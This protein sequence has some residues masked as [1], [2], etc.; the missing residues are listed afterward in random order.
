M[1][2]LVLA[3]FSGV[4]TTSA[5]SRRAAAESANTSIELTLEP[6]YVPVVQ[7]AGPRNEMW[8]A[9]QADSRVD[10]FD[11]ENWLLT[12]YDTVSGGQ[13]RRLTANGHINDFAF[14]DRDRVFVL[15]SNHALNTTVVMRVE[16]SGVQSFGE[17]E[18]PFFYGAQ[19]ELGRDGFIYIHGP[20]GTGSAL[21]QMDPDSLDVVN[22][23]T[24]VPHGQ[25]KAVEQGIVTHGV[26][27]ARLKPYGAS[28]PEQDLFYPPRSYG[29]ASVGD[30]GALHHLGVQLDPAGDSPCQLAQVSKVTLD[31]ELWVKELSE[32][33]S[34]ASDEVCIVR[35]I[36][37]LPDGGTVVT[38][39]R[40]RPEPAGN[41]GVVELYWLDRLG[42]FVDFR[43]PPV[44]ETDPLTPGF[45]FDGTGPLWL[46]NPAVTVDDV[47]NVA[48]A[49]A[50][51]DHICDPLMPLPVA[52]SNIYL[53]IYSPTLT[54]L[55]HGVVLPG[56]IPQEWALGGG[57]LTMVNGAIVVPF[58]RNHINEFCCATFHLALVRAND[59]SVG[60]SGPP[61]SEV[62]PAGSGAEGETKE[63]GDTNCDGFVRVAI[64]GDSYIS[65]EGA[66]DGITSTLEFN[67]EPK[68][69]EIGTDDRGVNQ[70]HRSQASWAWRVAADR[71]Q[72]DSIFFSACSGAVTHNVTFNGSPQWPV[73]ALL[74]GQPQSNSLNEYNQ[75][76]P[77]DLV[78]VSIG[79]ND[80]GFE[81]VIRDCLLFDCMRFP[82][83]SWRGDALREARTIGGRVRDTLLDIASSAPEAQVW[84]VGYPDPVAAR[85]CGATGPGIDFPALLTLLGFP[86]G[87][88]LGLLRIDR[89]EQAWI[90]ENFIGPLNQQVEAAAA[91]ANAQ[92][93]PFEN[94]FIGRDVCAGSDSAYTNGLK[95]GD[96]LPKPPGR[97]PLGAE[98]FHPNAMGHRHLSSVFWN[99]ATASGLL[100]SGAT[101]VAPSIQV[102][103]LPP[104]PSLTV[105][106]PPLNSSGLFVAAPG[107]PFALQGAGAPP[108]GSGVISFNS[109]P[110]IIG[111]FIADE[112]GAWTATVTIPASAAPGFHLLAAMTHDGVQLAS[113]L[114]PVNTSATCAPD[115]QSIDVD[116]DLLPN[117]CDPDQL[118]GPLA[119]FDEDTVA[120]DVDNCPALANTDQTDANDNG[121]GD[122][123]DPALGKPLTSG[124]RDLI[125]PTVVT[126][127][128]SLEGNVVGGFNG[129]IPP[130]LVSDPTDPVGVV[131]L[132]SDAPS[133]SPLGVSSVLWTAT[134]PSGNQAS[135]T[136]HVTVIDSV[137]P[138][139]TC[140][141]DVEATAG[142]SVVLGVATAIDIVDAAP[143]IASDAPLVFPNGLTS[144]VWT[145]RDGSGNTATCG[146]TV[147][148]TPAPNQAPTTGPDVYATPRNQGLTVKAPGVLGND[149]DPDPGDT[150]QA[151]LVAGASHGVVTLGVDGSV[152]Y[153]PDD[154]YVGPDSF[155]YAAVDQHSTW[156][157]PRT[158]TI[159]VTAPECVGLGRVDRVDTDVRA[160][161]AR[162]EIE[163]DKHP[164]RS[165]TR[166]KGEV[167]IED[168]SRRVDL[169]GRA[170]DTTTVVVDRTVCRGVVV[171]I[172]ASGKID[173]KKVRGTL[174]IRLD[175]RPSATG[176]SI[177]V[178][179]E[180]QTWTYTT[181]RGSVGIRPR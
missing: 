171:T 28:E 66:A 5:D 30:D 159:T 78:L 27:D 133:L 165:S 132:T 15:I 25:I 86:P 127:A 178:T 41:P 84:M 113:M 11:P 149:S 95:G 45:F 67:E 88:A 50:A 119:D 71:L 120:N 81:R 70:C 110:T 52:C 100:G 63:P 93:V 180:Q 60:S 143:P 98:S 91:A 156:S 128:A 29:S 36:D 142:G 75:D 111:G 161:R 181:T 101:Y 146:Q 3:V 14:D 22:I 123:C 77:I 53:S 16:P 94:A 152:V 46:L 64:V 48:V 129:P 166:W 69:Y 2:L 9:S 114:V 176:D 79:G 147:V 104:R 155:T 55:Q 6:G 125:G 141:V 34:V 13:V 162:I 130:P 148:V 105:T 140:P 102:L 99:R 121:A 131:T 124:L 23:F 44:P 157:A 24:G 175:D 117:H 19:L 74:G 136:Q 89:G 134:D 90:K 62:C 73:S 96:D 65:G 59:I 1:A 137:P 92:F 4:V 40:K 58:D 39:V 150:L 8:V 56:T 167:S 116:G 51:P 144:V 164:S 97:G 32:V 168:P 145:A 20:W 31:G 151:V 169:Q 61:P 135:A 33:A 57:E 43:S 115:M 12:V 17:I 154:G 108:A 85:T 68:P 177:T 80:I 103:P 106:N 179:F 49:V 139:I 107:S 7:W 47:G 21:V 174:T 82:F 38:L 26:F 173:G 18:E 172:P 118:D 153:A 138:T 76:H 126:S 87:S 72:A 35:E 160:G 112:H 158:V 37:A 122:A 10:E 163:L 170:T 42:N 109:L 83:N 54:L